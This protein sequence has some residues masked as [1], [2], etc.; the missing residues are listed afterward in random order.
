M[1][2]TLVDL[3]PLVVLPVGFL[4][5]IRIPGIGSFGFENGSGNVIQRDIPVSNFKKV[6]LAG[7]GNLHIEQ[8]EEESLHIEGEDN[9]LDLLRIEVL[10][11]ELHIGFERGAVIPHLTKPL[12]FTLKAKTMEGITLSG[13]GNVDAGSLH[14]ERLNLSISGAGDMETE[15][16]EVGDL[17]MK[18]SGSGDLE[19]GAITA[20]KTNLTISGR[21]NIK[22]KALHS[23]TLM[24]KISGSGNIHFADLQG[25]KIESKISGH[26][27]FELSGRVDEQ[28]VHLS[29]AG[30]YKASGLASR[31]TQVHISG[32]G[33]A[34]VQAEEEL[35]AHVS[36]A[37]NVRYSGQP[38]VNFRTS[39]IGKI[40]Q[41]QE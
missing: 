19:T 27:D 41:V 25:Q 23:A 1:K 36:G 24:L 4:A 39:G 16:L 2:T 8:C 26:G 37:G 33:N 20:G 17:E 38:R 12:N 15:T 35:D 31:R 11:D 22:A 30:N 6:R 32:V 34:D 28:E 10:Q 40:K 21:G 18:I 14:G 3:L 7:L 13:A 9:I 5:A 29:G